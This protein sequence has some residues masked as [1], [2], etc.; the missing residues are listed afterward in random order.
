MGYYIQVPK[1]LYKANQIMALYDAEKINEPSSLS[2]I[3]VNEAV[4]CV[5]EN[6]LFDAA[7]FCYSERELQAFAYPDGRKKTWLKMDRALAEKLTGFR[8]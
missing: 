8:S 6:G 5:V 7:G 3:P 1:D 4:I 2:G